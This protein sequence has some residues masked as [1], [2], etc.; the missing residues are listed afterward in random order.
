MSHQI[1]TFSLP[2]GEHVSGTPL[3]IKGYTLT[4]NTP[5]PTFYIQS[6]IHGGEITYWI[7]ERIFE[8]LKNHDFCGKVVIVPL[9]NPM[10]WMQRVYF[11]TVGKFDLYGGI[12]WNRNF[13]GKED[14]S[15]GERMASALFGLAKNSDFVLDLHTSRHSVPFNILSAPE[16]LKLAK[17]MGLKYNFLMNLNDDSSLS[18]YKSSLNGQLYEAKIPNLTVECGSHD[19][20]Q[21]ENVEEVTNGILSLLFSQGILKE[22]PQ[23]SLQNIKNP[24]NDQLNNQPKKQLY[25]T[26]LNTYFAPDGGFVEYCV[27]IGEEYKKDQVLYKLHKPSQIGVITESLAKEDGVLQKQAPTHI[28]WPG[29]E[30]VQTIAMNNFVEF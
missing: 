24:Q 8:Y 9:A 23:E 13:P 3:E 28:I 19:S 21:K 27:D 30:V 26:K 7:V 16:D 4:S 5:G 6:G 14:G 20:Y 17:S 11:A 22:A 12:D 25:Y 15:L 29:D 2:L 18:K 10:A 1:S